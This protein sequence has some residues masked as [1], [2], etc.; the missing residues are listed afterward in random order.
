MYE[1]IFQYREEIRLFL[2]SESSY[3]VADYSFRNS[4]NKK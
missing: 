3:L 1:R 2:R 4:T